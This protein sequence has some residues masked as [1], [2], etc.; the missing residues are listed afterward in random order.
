MSITEEMKENI[1]RHYGETDEDLKDLAAVMDALNDLEAVE[2]LKRSLETAK[3]ESEKALKDL[4]ASWRTRY[5]ERFFDG[6]VT[7]PDIVDL[8]AEADDEPENIT[9]EEF[10]KE[11]E[12]GR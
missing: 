9:I 7:T 12:K 3:L 4:D 1:K 5:R 2:D 6:D 10:L 11:M 8:D